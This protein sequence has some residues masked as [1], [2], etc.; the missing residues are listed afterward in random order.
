[1][2]TLP[3]SLILKPEPKIQS[4]KGDY[5]FRRLRK[6]KSGGAKFLNLRVLATRDACVKVG[7]VTSKKVGKAV[8]RNL[9]RRRVREGLKAIL[10]DKPIQPQFCS[11]LASFDV[12]IIIHTEA[13]QANYWQLKGALQYALAKAGVLK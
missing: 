11:T 1:V 9:I 12:V 7:I 8:V 13:T 4:L 5:A 10:Q 3:Q 6:G 2:N